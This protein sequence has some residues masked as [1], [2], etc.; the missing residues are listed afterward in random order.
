MQRKLPFN[1]HNNRG[2]RQI[3]RASVCQCQL[4]VTT[5]RQRQ[6]GVTSCWHWHD[7]AHSKARIYGKLIV[8]H[9]ARLIHDGPFFHF[10]SI[11]G[12]ITDHHG[13][14]I[15]TRPH[16][17]PKPALHTLSST[18]SCPD[19]IVHSKK[20]LVDNVRILFSKVFGKYLPLRLRWP[21]TPQ[22]SSTCNSR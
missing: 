6:K 10:S 9:K 1:K 14:C 19:D 16:R 4:Q 13:L 2:E 11:Y 15:L 12:I 7:T 17:L 22:P 21:K 20:K 3:M 18:R 5:A 8:R